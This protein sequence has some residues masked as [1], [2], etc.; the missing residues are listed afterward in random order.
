MIDPK[1][2]YANKKLCLSLVPSYTFKSKFSILLNLFYF[3]H[4]TQMLIYLKIKTFALQFGASKICSSIYF[5]FVKCCLRLQHKYFAYGFSDSGTF[6]FATVDS[7]P[8]VD[9]LPLYHEGD[10][11]CALH[12]PRHLVYHSAAL[13]IVVS[14]AR[15]RRPPPTRSHPMAGSAFYVSPRPS[16]L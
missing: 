12:L 6:P 4:M 11:L 15:S 3:T 16:Q 10:L 5:L 2:L 1:S 8:M 13:P 7:H 9:T 14:A